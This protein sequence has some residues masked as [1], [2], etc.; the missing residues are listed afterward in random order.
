MEMAVRCFVSARTLLIFLVSEWEMGCLEALPVVSAFSAI[1]LMVLDDQMVASLC[2][3]R[4][5]RV[6]SLHTLC[7]RHLESSTMT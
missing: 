7:A 1:A 4:C 2:L 6:P 3:H 5:T